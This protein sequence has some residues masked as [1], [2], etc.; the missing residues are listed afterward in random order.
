MMLNAGGRPAASTYHAN[1]DLS[2]N[3]VS[4][5]D[6][7]TFADD[8][9]SRIADE[10]QRNTTPRANNTSSNDESKREQIMERSG[11]RNNPFK[12]SVPQHD[13]EK[14]TS[15]E[16]E[17]QQISPR[18]SVTQS[19]TGEIELGLR[20]K[21]VVKKVSSRS[22]DMDG[23]NTS[24]LS[25]SSMPEEEGADFQSQ[26]TNDIRHRRSGSQDDYFCDEHL[27][28]P[29]S[30][31]QDKGDPLDLSRH[32]VPDNLASIDSPSAT[33]MDSSVSSKKR[34]GFKRKDSANFF[35]DDSSHADIEANLSCSPRSD[36]SDGSES[37]IGSGR[38]RSMGVEFG[39][40]WQ[41][42][43]EKRAVEQWTIQIYEQYH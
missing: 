27:D 20:P 2:E 29:P 30:S 41:P 36:R 40:R 28:R 4:T 18:T 14:A 32:S 10:W 37:V 35:L 17:E 5:I 33:R 34:V 3:T 15:N 21:A 31:Y 6:D 8:P 42:D 19:N 9:F 38:F 11:K 16:L 7:D 39:Y 22:P 26:V 13:N 1:D 43:E 12:I 23:S 24:L 25:L